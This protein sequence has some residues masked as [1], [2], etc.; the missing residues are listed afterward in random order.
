M[1]VCLAG[2]YAGAVGYFGLG[3]TI[4]TCIAIRTMVFHKGTAYLQAGGG[5][6]YDSDEQSEWE[7]TMNKL[8]GNLTAIDRAER[9]YYA[10]QQKSNTNGSGSD[11]NNSNSTKREGSHD[12]QDHQS[13][14]RVC[15]E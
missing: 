15:V 11:N 6:V 2:V 13:T 14:K 5:I 7:E 10:L 1:D 12:D 9:H 8:R 4:D 3:G